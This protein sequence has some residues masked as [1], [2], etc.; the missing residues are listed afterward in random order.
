MVGY[1]KNRLC[2]FMNVVKLLL[3]EEGRNSETCYSDINCVDFDFFSNYSIFY[4]K[5]IEATTDPQK[6]QKEQLQKK[7]ENL[8]EKQ[9]KSSLHARFL[10][11][12]I[13][14]ECVPEGM[15]LKKKIYVGKNFSDLQ[16]SVDDLLKKVSLDICDK[17][18]SAHQQKVRQ[19]GT[20]M[21][22]LRHILKTKSDD[23]Y[24]SEFDQKVFEKTEKKK[25]SIL[26]KQ[27]MKLKRLQQ[28][29]RYPPVDT[30]QTTSEIPKPK[31]KKKQK[32]Q[33]KKAK[34]K[35]INKPTHQR[36]CNK[37]QRSK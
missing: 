23:E 11:N 30:Q 13:E 22:S 32:K 6:L 37:T 26:E 15:L 35:H 14:S 36:K 9:M 20:E 7:F 4:I 18:S 16:K 3:S 12:C 10:Q 27:N 21:E 34:P 24:V 8:A 17:V 29:D 31:P 33:S 1:E 25:N 28:K 5:I 19:I 2:I